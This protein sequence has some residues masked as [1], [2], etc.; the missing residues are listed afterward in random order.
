MNKKYFLLSAAVLAF[1]ASAFAAPPAEEGKSANKKHFESY[2]KARLAKIN[3]HHKER[4]GFMAQEADTWNSFWSKIRD[5]R[6][7]FEIRMTRQTLD[8]FE[9][10][11]SLD[12]RDHAQTIADFEKMQGNVVKAFDLQQKGKLGEF[13]AAREARWKDFVAAQERERGDFLAQA[14]A[15]WQQS[16]ADLKNPGASASAEADKAAAPGH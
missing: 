11:A 2:L 5:E 3:D 8:L 10:L 7:L 15:D 14:T 4:M 12:S 16:K 9:S 1:A 6:K 13:F